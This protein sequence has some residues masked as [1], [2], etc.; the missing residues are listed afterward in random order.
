MQRKTKAKEATKLRKKDYK[1][2]KICTRHIKKGNWKR[3]IQFK[4]HKKE[5]AKI[6]LEKVD[7][8]LKT[9]DFKKNPQ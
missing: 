5:Q 3:H 2:C 6:I 7:K 1:W 8:S 9:S 4:T